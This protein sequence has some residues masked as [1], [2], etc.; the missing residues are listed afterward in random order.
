MKLSQRYLLEYLDFGFSSGSD[1]GHATKSMNKN[2]WKI[3]KKQAKSKRHSYALKEVQ[4]IL[5]RLKNYKI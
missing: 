5:K 2:F 1:M 3:L 4:G